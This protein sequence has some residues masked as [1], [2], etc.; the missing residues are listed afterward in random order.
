M[1]GHILVATWRR[2]VALARDGRDS[3][4]QLAENQARDNTRETTK[5]SQQGEPGF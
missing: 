4:W 3:A 1:L 2:L 5:A